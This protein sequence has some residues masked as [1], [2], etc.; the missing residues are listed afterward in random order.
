M[1]VDQFGPSSFRNRMDLPQTVNSVL[2]PEFQNNTFVTALKQRLL[3]PFVSGESLARIETSPE[4]A[5]ESEKQDDEE[6][7]LM[8]SRHDDDD[9]AMDS[10]LPTVRGRAHCVVLN[11]RWSVGH[12]V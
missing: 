12:F 5:A 11:D 4:P 7:K 2:V 3:F 9:M 6:E 1:H 8:Y 10:L